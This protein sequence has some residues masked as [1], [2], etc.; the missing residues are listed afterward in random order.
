[1][2]RT[3]IKRTPFRRKPGAKQL[4]RTV[5]LKPMNAER[6]AKRRTA[7]RRKL[8]KSR[9]SEGYKAAWARSE[10]RCEYTHVVQEG[11][12]DR[13]V[14]CVQT[15]QLDAHHLTYRRFGGDELETDYLILCPYHHALIE[16]QQHPHRK[17]RRFA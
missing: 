1:M 7:Y 6:H 15:E 2:K 11:Y 14:R 10:G 17:A 5:K 8:A 16:E 9:R 4:H 13:G 12:R 3:E